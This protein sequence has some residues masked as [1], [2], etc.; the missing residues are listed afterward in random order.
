M[1]LAISLV[2]ST[3]KSLTWSSSPFVYSDWFSAYCSWRDLHCQSRAT[4]H[5]NWDE[6]TWTFNTPNHPPDWLIGNECLCYSDHYIQ[7]MVWLIHVCYELS[8]TLIR[9]YRSQIKIYLWNQPKTTQVERILLLLIESGF[10]YISIWVNLRLSVQS[11]WSY[12]LTLDFLIVHQHWDCSTI[13]LSHHR[14]D[15]TP[16]SCKSEFCYS[17]AKNNPWQGIYPLLVILIVEHYKSVDVSLPGTMS[18]PI[19]YTTFAESWTTS[20]QYY[21]NHWSH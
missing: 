5:S 4:W 2:A 7:D 16:Y 6:T 10:A 11:F 14:G 13:T 3:G 8:M 17:L 20:S 15:F 9:I 12:S 21:I 1:M 19:Q 18:H